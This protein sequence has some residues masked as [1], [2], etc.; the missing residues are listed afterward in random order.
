LTAELTG[1]HKS[2]EEQAEYAA[3]TAASG[4]RFLEVI[5][6]LLSQLL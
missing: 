3:Q 1:K 4:D 2:L 6:T 5:C